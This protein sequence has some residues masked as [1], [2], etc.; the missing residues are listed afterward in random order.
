MNRVK[1]SGAKR[2]FTFNEWD[3]LQAIE[4]RLLST[5]R[6]GKV[7]AKYKDQEVIMTDSIVQDQW[8]LDW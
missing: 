6:E 8:D 7:V 4:A 2:D 3:K 5:I 1:V